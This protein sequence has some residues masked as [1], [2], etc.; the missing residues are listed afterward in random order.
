MELYDL[1]AFRRQKDKC[2]SLTNPRM[3]TGF[4]SCQQL[5]VTRKSKNWCG[6]G[7]GRHSPVAL[8]AGMLTSPPGEPELCEDLFRDWEHFWLNPVCRV[9][10]G[11]IWEIQLFLLVLPLVSVHD[12]DVLKCGVRMGGLCWAGSSCLLE[13]CHSHAACLVCAWEVGMSWWHSS[14]A[15]PRAL[16]SGNALNFFTTSFQEFSVDCW[17]GREPLFSACVALGNA[18]QTSK[19]EVP[20]HLLLT[21]YVLSGRKSFL[22]SNPHFPFCKSITSVF[23]TCIANRKRIFQPAKVTLCLTLT[24]TFHSSPTHSCPFLKSLCAIFPPP[25]FSLVGRYFRKL[26]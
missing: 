2:S 7:V 3:T 12:I 14:C 9:A 25:F 4:A 23:C 15:S 6:K 17:T 16:P 8:R 20:W 5:K 11:K 10:P 21:N 13:L 22:H 1:A 18:L 26:S 19:A 24:G